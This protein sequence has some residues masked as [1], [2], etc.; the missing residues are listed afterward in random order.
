MNHKRDQRECV[1]S[2]VRRGTAR[3]RRPTTKDGHTSC[4][5]CTFP[6]SDLATSPRWSRSFFNSYRRSGT[7]NVGLAITCLSNGILIASFYSPIACYICADG[8]KGS[9]ATAGACMQCNKSGCKQQFHVTCAQQLGLLCEEAG[10]YL[11]N[12]KYCG[13]CQHHYSKLVSSKAG[14]FIRIT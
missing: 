6:K 14:G 10:N 8:G 12:V 11:D 5:P 2:C 7:T 4:V 9:K 13:Y 3:S 1:A